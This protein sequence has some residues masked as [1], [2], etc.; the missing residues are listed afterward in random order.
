MSN[1]EG[2]KGVKVERRNRRTEALE[3]VV[4]KQI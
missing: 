3:K 4:T 2:R 1:G